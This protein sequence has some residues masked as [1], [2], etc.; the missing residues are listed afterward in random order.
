MDLDLCSLPPRPDLLGDLVAELG[1]IPPGGDPD[2]L[3]S[4]LPRVTELAR[5]SIVVVAGASVTLVQSRGPRTLAPSGPLAS[6][7]DEQQYR[8]GTGP[9]TDA[10]RSGQQLLVEHGDDRIYPAFSDAAR[11]AGVSHTLSIGLTLPGQPASLNLYVCASGRVPAGVLDRA[12]QLAGYA[13]VVLGEAT[14]QRV[15]AVR[16]EELRSALRTHDVVEA[17]REIVMRR[18]DLDR[19]AALRLLGCDASRQVVPL[20]VL[21]QRVI[22]GV[23]TY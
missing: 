16:A 23:L 8:L 6:Q 14:G 1:P 17:A 2:P 20:R 10:A 19:V 11:S 18:R 22:D 5:R 4:L 3:T 7:L 9:C 13:A 21:A 12:D 15:A